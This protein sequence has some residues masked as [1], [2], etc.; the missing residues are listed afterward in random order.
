MKLLAIAGD[1]Q[2]LIADIRLVTPLRTLCAQQGWS[3]ALRS[4]HDCRR[5]DL[6]AA[7]VLVVQRA[8][9]ARAWRLQ[10]AMRQ[11]GGAVVY[12]IDDLLTEIAPHISNHA[13]VQAQQAWLRRCLSESDVVSVSTG[14]LGQLLADTV[15]LPA[16]QVVPN[17]APPGDAQ[18]LPAQTPGRVTL[19]LAS[20]DQ[21]DTDFIFP[22]LRALQGPDV[23]L[24]VVGPPGAAFEAAGLDVRR[25][26]LRP[27]ADF[28]A[29]ARSLPNPLA[30]IP[31]EDSRFAAGK[32]AIK[33]FDYA[34]IG[35][36]TLAS[37]HSPYL[38]VID[39]GRT[40]WLVANDAAAWLRALR[41]AIADPVARMRVAVAAR[42]AVRE[43]HG[44]ARTVDAWQQAV[45]L[46]LQQRAGARL[47]APTLH[48]RLQMALGGW[49][50]D[51]VARL[52]AL[53]RARLAQ[54]RRPPA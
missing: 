25:E 15:A 30:V 39:D 34:E 22:A 11:R 8:A 12:D 19:L 54:R 52:R 48:E 3:L 7:D 9:S 5:A 33:W 16:T 23:Q 32:S 36:P 47:P 31:L 28:L 14:R 41:A 44:L 20:S 40:G 29:L 42:R 21:L 24:V 46:A 1:I 53:N 37:R 27:R 38:E 2:A 4:F 6:A 45:A 50:E 13:A 18:P 49:V 35:V 26:P 10:R 43:R 17:H 51:G